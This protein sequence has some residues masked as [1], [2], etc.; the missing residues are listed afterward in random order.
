MARIPSQSPTRTQMSQ[1][2]AREFSD[3]VASQMW[4]L[5]ECPSGT[6]G[7]GCLLHHQDSNGA[8]T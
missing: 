2:R 6:V 4:L 8:G 5:Y 3:P 7:G 1:Q